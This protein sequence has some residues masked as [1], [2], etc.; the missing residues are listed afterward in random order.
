MEPHPAT[1][2]VPAEVV[3]A[4]AVSDSSGYVV[5]CKF[6]SIHEEDRAAI[7][8]YTFERQRELARIRSKD[9]TEGEQE[10]LGGVEENFDELGQD[11]G[12]NRGAFRTEERFQVEYQVVSEAE[13][14]KL[15]DIFR[16]K[17]TS[18]RGDGIASGE[19][20]EQLSL[21]G[22]SQVEIQMFQQI[23]RSMNQIV[24]KLDEVK[25]VLGGD[26][27]SSSKLLK[28]IC[29]DLSSGGMRI[30]SPQPIA[31]EDI[32]RLVIPLPPLHPVVVSVLGKVMKLTNVRLASGKKGYEAAIRFEVIREL[33]Q[34]EIVSYGFKRQREEMSS[35]ASE[36][37]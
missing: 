12:Q 15:S 11:S 28:A 17:R 18:E 24:D 13:F 35:R 36:E 8:A 22:G 5:A 37:S 14:K 6:A 9:V 3:R 29:I 21:L 16:Y 23:M 30:V 7:I 2:V 25:D 26:S 19:S 27:V 34:E 10:W 20:T 31:N 32:L 1:V 33:D 4:E